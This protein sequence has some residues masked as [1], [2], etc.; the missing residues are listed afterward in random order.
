MKLNNKASFDLT[1]QG[2]NPERV[3]KSESMTKG[4]GLTTVLTFAGNMQ[5]IN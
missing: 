1:E 5:K 4:L 3:L 2:L